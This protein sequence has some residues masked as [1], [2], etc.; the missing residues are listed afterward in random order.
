MTDI[1]IRVEGLSKQ[2]KI[3][4]AKTRHDTVRD[5]IVDYGGRLAKWWRH[6]DSHPQNDDPSHIWALKDVSFEVKR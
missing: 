1:A 2:Y 5:T 4:V 3:G 6:P